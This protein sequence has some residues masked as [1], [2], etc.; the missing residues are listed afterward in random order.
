[1]GA[2][3]WKVLLHHC[4]STVC[5]YSWKKSQPHSNSLLLYCLKRRELQ[6][7]SS[8]S[9]PSFSEDKPLKITYKPPMASPGNWVRLADGNTVLDLAPKTSSEVANLPAKILLSPSSKHC[10]QGWILLHTVLRGY[11]QGIFKK[12]KSSSTTLLAAGKSF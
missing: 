3:S 5:S 9:S 1:M 10:T 11:T 6:D 2:P 12:G 7:R 8:D 4:L